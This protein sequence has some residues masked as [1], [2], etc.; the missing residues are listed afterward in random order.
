MLLKAVLFPIFQAKFDAVLLFLPPGVFQEDGGLPVEVYNQ[1][2]LLLLQFFVL[3]V[4]VVFL[5]VPIYCRW[6]D[7]IPGTM[8]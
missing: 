4:A 2:L 1:R 3:W 6:F 7:A 8:D 5:P